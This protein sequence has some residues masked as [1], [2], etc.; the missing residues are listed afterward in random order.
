M[1]TITVEAPNVTLTDMRIMDNATTGVH[2]MAPGVTVRRVVLAR[3]GMMGMTATQ[4]DGLQVR[5]VRV[6]RNNAE[7]FNAAPSAGGLKIDRSSEITVRDSTFVANHGTGLWFDESVYRLAVVGSRMA[8]NDGHGLALEISGSADVV[9]NLIVDNAGDGIKINDTDHVRVWN[10]TLARNGR[11]LNVVQDGRDVDPD[12]SYR[13]W[14]LPLT[15]R[16]GPISLSNNVVAAPRSSANCLL[17]VEDY[18]GRFSAEDMQVTALGN[19]YQ[20]TRADNPGWAVVWSV[21]PGDPAVF[22]NLEAFRAQTGQESPGKLL[23]GQAAVS[24]TNNLTSAVRRLRSHVA[25]PV[26]AWLAELA[27]VRAGARHLGSWRR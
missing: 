13:D 23:T 21:G 16:N 11:P 17:C 1:G 22:D 4:A 7:L 6:R 2:V 25:L 12:G 5:G 15:Y 3:N 8:K 9:D 26:P 14:T 20:R 18:S 24:A 10:N 27:G 19:L